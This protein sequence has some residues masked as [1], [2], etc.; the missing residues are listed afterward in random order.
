MNVSIVIPTLNEEEGIQKTLRELSLFLLK[1]KKLKVELIII[2]GGSEDRTVKI[3]REAGAK[4]IIAE[5]GYG[6]QYKAGFKEAKG[7][8]IITMDGDGTYPVE[9]V[10]KL[11]EVLEKENLDFIS[12]NRFSNLGKTSINKVNLIGNVFLTFFT[13]LLFNLHLVDSQSGMWIFR[14][15]ILPKLNLVS[16]GMSFSEEI[17]IEAFQKSKAKE[18]LGSYYKRMGGRSKLKFSDGIKNLFFLFK[19]KFNL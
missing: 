9:E 16:N 2:D 4:V 15:D 19:K 18:I 7:D 3:A 10:S 14:K 11:L 6:R 13:N 8:V 1:N 17:K 12:L 5:R